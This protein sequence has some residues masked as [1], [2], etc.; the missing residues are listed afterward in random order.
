M[1]VQVNNKT[2]PLSLAHEQKR[3]AKARA[4]SMAIEGVKKYQ[5]IKPELK[6]KLDAILTDED[7]AKVEPVIDEALFKLAAE[8]AMYQKLLED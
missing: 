7:M 6:N 5:A 4:E 1:K 3:L 8:A 2:E